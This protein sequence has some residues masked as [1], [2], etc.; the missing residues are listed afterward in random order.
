M[1][2]EF[3]MKKNYT[4]AATLSNNQHLK[5]QIKSIYYEETADFCFVLSPLKHCFNQ[6]LFTIPESYSLFLFFSEPF[7]FSSPK[8]LSSVTFLT[9]RAT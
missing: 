2:V 3:I 8:K 7:N 1:F 5:K 6:N 4:K 9:P